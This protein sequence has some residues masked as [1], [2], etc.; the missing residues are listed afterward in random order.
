MSIE[1]KSIMTNRSTMKY[2]VFGT[3]KKDFIL[4]PGVGIRD[5]TLSAEA[6][7]EYYKPFSEDYRVYV[8]DI[9][10]D[11]PEE[12][13]IDDMTEDLYEAIIGLGVQKAYFN[14]CSMGGMIVQRMEIKHPELVIKGVLS[15][16]ICTISKQAEGTLT[17]WRDLTA[18][19]DL[20][21]L[22]EYSCQQVYTKEFYEKFY[23]FLID[24]H[25][26]ADKE[27]ARRFIIQ[28]NAILDYDNKEVSETTP[29]TLVITA[30]GDQTFSYLEA[31]DM[32][33]K[34]GCE[35]LVYEGYSHA[36]YDEAPDYLEK[37]KEFF[38]K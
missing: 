32:A 35:A 7:V 37:V 20:K 34:I 31:V 28:L 38:E 25:V 10:E 19:G 4:V 22:A 30:K 8:F 21:K 18:A 26:N 3:G 23:D 11:L 15:S 29:K 36:V 9:R 13:T 17:F 1:I 6:I 12:Y 14:G 24:Y 27:D 33:E 16:T 2:F 5:N